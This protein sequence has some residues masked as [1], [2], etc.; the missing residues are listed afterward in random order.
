MNLSRVPL[1]RLGMVP[2][3]TPGTSWHST[4]WEAAPGG[5]LSRKKTRRRRASLL[6]LRGAGG[7]GA[8]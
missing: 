5:W 6:Y 2:K 7:T 4:V 1:A 3:A 8:V